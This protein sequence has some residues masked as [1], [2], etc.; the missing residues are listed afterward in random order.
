M[1][2]IQRQKIAKQEE[3]FAVYELNHALIDGLFET[4]PKMKKGYLQ[5]RE[6][7]R[8][9]TVI[10]KD[11]ETG[12]QRQ[13]H[14]TLTFMAP[15]VLN[16]TAESILLAI[17]SLAKQDGLSIEP[18]QLTSPFTLAEGDAQVRN[19]VQITCTMYQLMKLAGMGDGKKYYELAKFYMEQMGRATVKWEN[20]TSGWWGLTNILQ[21]TSDSDGRVIAQTN[22]RLAGALLGNYYHARIDLNERH[23]LRKDASKTLHRWLSA[24]L[25]QHNGKAEYIKYDTLVEHIWTEEVTPGTKR[26][27]LHILK[28]E[29]LPEIGSLTKWVVEMQTEGAIITH[30]KSDFHTKRDIQKA[31]VEKANRKRIKK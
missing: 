30:C 22:W 1:T 3:S 19:K 29:I 23:V 18:E 25:W 17:L 24:H 16:A 7:I 28:T 20:H 13:E 9:I 14:I 6:V 26:W 12:W 4:S 11:P 27:R 21:F 10:G 2:I 31:I 15:R 8:N 5:Y